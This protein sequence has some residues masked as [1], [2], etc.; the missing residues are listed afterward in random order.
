M[1]LALIDHWQLPEA[2]ELIR[3]LQPLVREW[4]L[5]ICL[6]GGV[7][8]KGE[9]KKDLDLFILPLGGKPT[10]NYEKAKG[11]LETLWGKGEKLFPNL[12]NYDPELVTDGRPPLRVTLPTATADDLPVQANANPFLDGTTRGTI[13]YTPT[14]VALVPETRRNEIYKGGAF[15]YDFGGLRIDVFFL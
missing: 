8:N 5:H 4:N 9:S 10:P 2:L 12:E 7:L 13:T 14:P 6:G 1:S 11:F 15:K 3:T